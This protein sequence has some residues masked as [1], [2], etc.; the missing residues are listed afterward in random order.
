[1]EI[2]CP[3]NLTTMSDQKSG[4][5][6][7]KLKNFFHLFCLILT[8]NSSNNIYNVFKRPKLAVNHIS[9]YFRAKSHFWKFWLQKIGIFTSKWAKF[10]NFENFFCHLWFFGVWY[11][12][13]FF[14]KRR[15]MQSCQLALNRFWIGNLVMKKSRKN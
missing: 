8:K 3:K 15:V 5:R 4:M 6:P 2:K 14:A 11:E 1:M 9:P 13:N 7:Q 12:K 10:A